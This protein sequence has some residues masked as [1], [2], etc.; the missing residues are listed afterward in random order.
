MSN[1]DV[2]RG[3]RQMPAL[4]RHFALGTIYDA[5]KDEIIPGN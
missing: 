4:G 5:I 1:R 2:I 3:M